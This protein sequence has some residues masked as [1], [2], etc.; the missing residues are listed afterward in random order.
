MKAISRLEPNEGVPLIIFYLSSCK[1]CRTLFVMRCTSLI[2]AFDL[3][4]RGHSRNG[5]SQGH[6][7]GVCPFCCPQ[8]LHR[9]ICNS[10]WACQHQTFGN[11]AISA[12]TVNYWYMNRMLKSHIFCPV[13]FFYISITNAK[14]HYNKSIK[15]RL[16]FNSYVEHEGPPFKWRLTKTVTV[17]NLA[18]IGDQALM[19]TIRWYNGNVSFQTQSSWNQMV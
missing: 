3:S 9:I 14:L 4:S 12:H 16:L 10:K 11:S 8:C 17:I 5:S 1:L 6:S 2:D 15:G 19:Q 13:C 7:R 18:V